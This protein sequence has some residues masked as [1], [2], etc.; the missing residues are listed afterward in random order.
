[1]VIARQYW[2]APRFDSC[3]SPLS[4]SSFLKPLP[5]S[6]ISPSLL[7][8]RFF[9]SLPPPPFFFSVCDPPLSPVCRV[10]DYI[11]Q[12]YTALLPHLPGLPYHRGTESGTFS[13]LPEERQLSRIWG[14]VLSSPIPA[15]KF[16]RPHF[17]EDECKCCTP[18][19]K[20]NLFCLSALP[21]IRPRTGGWG[22]LT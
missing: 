13:A 2:P 6:Q 16:S 22:P 15:T 7:R 17:V 18:N 5:L 19:L 3:H 1:M 20:K 12:H 14:K 4:A 8:L 9:V 21:R 11:Y 10:T